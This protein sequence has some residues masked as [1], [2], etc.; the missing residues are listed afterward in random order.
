ML[1]AVGTSTRAVG[2]DAKKD[3]RV[4][5]FARFG[6]GDK[7]QKFISSKVNNIERELARK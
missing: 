1:D 6:G 2:K 7:I 4:V 5:C 3:V